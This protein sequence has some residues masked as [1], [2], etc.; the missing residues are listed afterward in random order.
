MRTAQ[1]T[2]ALLATFAA[3]ACV[4][5]DEGRPETDDASPDLRDGGKGDGQSCDF[6]TM[7]GADYFEQFA[8]KNIGDDS[9]RR[10]RVGLTWDL[11]PVLENGD[12][13][14]VTA[15][16]L[17][18]G[19]VILNYSELRHDQGNRWFNENETVVITQATVDPDTR[20]LTIRGLGTG[21]PLTYTSNSGCGPAY[22]FEFTSDLRSPG[23]AGDAAPV[24]AGSTSA[25]VIDPDNLDAVPYESTRRWFQ[26]DVASGKIK[27]IRL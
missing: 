26:E 7:S 17:P 11:A 20:A 23:L 4:A 5:S 14:S 12:K 10:Y 15:Y 8:Y 9:W 24:I 6:D 2:A 18:A 21:T 3:S 16:F 1:L 19:R 25:F 27:I 22:D 13:A